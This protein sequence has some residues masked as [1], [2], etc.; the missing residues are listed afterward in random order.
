[1]FPE[2]VFFFSPFLFLQ[3]FHSFIHSF[4]HSPILKTATRRL[5][6]L[7][8]PLVLVLLWGGQHPEL[9]LSL[10]EA[11]NAQDLNWEDFAPTELENFL[12]ILSTEETECI[13]QASSPVDGPSAIFFLIHRI[14]LFT[15]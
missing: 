5:R 15:D 11:E 14:L 4:I 3:F 9:E 13:S 7:E 6:R 10:Q 2:G 8:E 1:L 12:R